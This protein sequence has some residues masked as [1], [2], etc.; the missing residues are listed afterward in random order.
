M[1]STA[2]LPNNNNQQQQQSVIGQS[3]LPN[4]NNN[5]PASQASSTTATTIAS[6]SFGSIGP[7]FAVISVLFVLTMLSCYFG[8][9]YGRRWAAAPLERIDIGGSG[10]GGGGSSSSCIGWMKNVKS[11][12]WMACHEFEVRRNNKMVVLCGDVDEKS[13]TKVRDH[14]EV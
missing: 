6:A 12:L 5:N 13:D 7:F 11:R 9:T 3:A 8:R 14:S 4:N 1:A 10:G 2:L